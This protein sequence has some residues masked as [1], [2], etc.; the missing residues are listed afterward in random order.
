MV[1]NILR[2]TTVRS[3]T[4][5]VNV[6]QYL[7]LEHLRMKYSNLL[8]TSFQKNNYAFKIYINSNFH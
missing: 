8:G 6:F 2:S 1:T 3:L 5:S 7:D 4:L